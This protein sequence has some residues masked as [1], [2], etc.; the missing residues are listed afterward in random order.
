MTSTTRATRTTTRVTTTTAPVTT[1]TRVTTTTAAPTTTAP[2]TTTTAV[3][4]TTAP[5]T[6]TTTTAP[7]TTTATSGTSTRRPW[8]WILAGVALAAAVVALLVLLRRRSRQRALSAWR[9]ESE[10]AL[11]SAHLSLS[12]LP[13]SPEEITD[14]AH[15]QSVRD[16]VEQ[17]AQALERAG[18]AAPTEDGARVARRTAEALRGL[19]FAL[20]AS[21]LLRT[22]AVTPTAE[23]LIE[24]DAAT[25]ERVGPMSTPLSTSSTVLSNRRRWAIQHHLPVPADPEAAGPI[26]SSSTHCVAGVLSGAVAG[27]GRPS[28]S[29]RYRSGNR[30]VASY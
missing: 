8:G 16:R 9:V 12:V 2:T 23:Q 22:A 6:V 30:L 24:A 1:T 19:V 13:T 18:T 17:A 28:V 29:T 25:R 26:P 3:T 4:S 5:A 14:D 15:W 11:D 21:R 7:V 10:K 20:E 27:G